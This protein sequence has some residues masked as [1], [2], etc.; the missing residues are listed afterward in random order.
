MSVSRWLTYL[1]RH[2]LRANGLHPR[3]GGWVRVRDV[4]NLK[5]YSASSIYDAI[6]VDY[7]GRFELFCC[8]AVCWI[9]AV[10][11]DVMLKRA[12]AVPRRRLHAPT[13]SGRVWRSAL[14][15]ASTKADDAPEDQCDDDNDVDSVQP[16]SRTANPR[17]VSPSASSSSAPARL[18]GPRAIIGRQLSRPG[19]MMPKPSSAPQLASIFYP[20]AFRCCASDK[21]SREAPGSPTSEWY[22]VEKTLDGDESSSLCLTIDGEL[23]VERA[24]ETGVVVDSFMAWR[25]PI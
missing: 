14:S 11:K 24:N 20:P 17:I 1:L 6:H 7:K 15:L 8:R 4:A 12:S 25:R 19:S 16:L 18:L 23:S 5:M 9:R 10:P 21:W 3:P 22:S 13:L 2:G